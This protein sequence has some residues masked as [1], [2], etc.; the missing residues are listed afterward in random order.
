MKPR[1]SF[2][3]PFIK[4]LQ[5]SEQL[6]GNRVVVFSGASIFGRLSWGLLFCCLLL[7]GC[8]EEEVQPNLEALPTVSAGDVFMLGNDEAAV[9]DIQDD[10]WCRCCQVCNC[11]SS[12]V[13]R[14]LVN[15]DTLT[16][17]DAGL[18]GFFFG[19]TFD[20]QPR[21]EYNGLTVSAT[22]FVLGECEDRLDPEAY[23]VDITVR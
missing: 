5:S 14:L 6:E 12:P 22:N 18:E 1:L 2:F 10:F 3:F 8:M 4:N 21:A 13:V 16:L 20:Y 9:L 17:F 23:T 11:A 15:T 7:T 19:S